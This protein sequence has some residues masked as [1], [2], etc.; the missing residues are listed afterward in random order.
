MKKR[1]QDPQPLGPLLEQVLSENGYLT[2][3]KEYG[4]VQKWPSI[5]TERLAAA[6]RCE[7]IE[8]GI[9]YVRVASAPWRQ[10]AVYLKE[11]ILLKIQKEMNCPTIKDIVFY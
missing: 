4:I 2:I 3:C 5:V 8:N 1:R 6:S 10:E 7:R 11:K 9:L